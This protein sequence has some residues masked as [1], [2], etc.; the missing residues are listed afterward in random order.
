MLRTVMIWLAMVV[1]LGWGTFPGR[2]SDALSTEPTRVFGLGEV[3]LLAASSDLRFVAS[4][5]Q[6][7]A[8]VWDIEGA[9]LRHRLDRRGA[10]T[11][12]AFSPD[13][14]V[15]LTATADGIHA[16]DTESGKERGEFIGHRRW[17]Q[18]LRFESTGDRFVSASDDN[19]ARVWSMATG[20]L[21]REIR[22]PGSPI[23]DADFTPDGLHL[24]TVD[25][26]L[27]NAVKIWELGSGNLAGFLPMTNLAVQRCLYAPS[28]HLVTVSGDRRV[29]RW[30]TVSGAKVRTYEGIVGDTA[31]IQDLWFP[32]ETT[33]AA[34]SN[35]G[36]VYLWN[37]ESGELL[38][39]VIGN[40]V[41]ASSGVA[42]D[43]LVVEAGLDY[44]IGIRQLPS[45]DTLRRF[46]GHTTSTHSGVA[47][48]P[49]GRFV[50]SAGTEAAAR[51]WDRKTGALIRTLVGSPAG[52]MA[53]SFS[54]DGRHVLT[55]VGLPNPSA[56]L[57][58][59]ETGEV[60]RDFGWSGSWPSSAALSKDGS[61][62]AAGAQD[63]R[64]RLYDSG[65]GG[66][67]RTM[68]GRG[69]ISR[70]A[71]SPAAP[72]LLSGEG[73]GDYQAVLYNH[74][75]GQPLDVFEANAGPVTALEFTSTGDRF[76]VGWQDGLIR[77][78]DA[79]TLEVRREW[80]LRAGFLDAA[81]FS[82]DGRWVLTGESFPLFNATLWD[83]ET[84]DGVRSFPGHGWVVGSVAFS[85]DGSR[86][87]TGAEVVREW[88][89]ADLA[90][91]LRIERM[92]DHS[93][94]SWQV[95]RLEFSE[96]PSGPWQVMSNAVSPYRETGA[97]QAGFYRVRVE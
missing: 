67:L 97:G 25:T 75:S 89:I 39:V 82:P 22:T 77:I 10:V 84:G 76:L 45:G 14:Q 8:V 86:I 34:T 27:T 43:S 18:R 15:L 35:D 61:R 5:G 3:R 96:V 53:A 13:G 26:F 44:V 64:I 20:E 51:L 95:G 23:L 54:S 41:M 60:E 2:C 31:L 73:A 81:R 37:L 70:L 42:G 94:I 83:T 9:R 19:T 62:V 46:V 33:L 48:S 6:A 85:A 11:A 56:R 38:K 68:V 17:I 21:L 50:L 88:S 59:A 71:F 69:W 1:A 78:F 7:G 65:T 66:L 4:G 90:A 57:W 87:L 79:F 63:S 92:A 32:N 93:R 36:R 16:W 12:L 29:T 74:E 55:T 52:T 91:R 72:L 58:N 28:G 49:D 80:V 30:N 47:F 40:P 24:V